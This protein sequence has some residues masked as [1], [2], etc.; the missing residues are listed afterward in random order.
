MALVAKDAL[1]FLDNLIRWSSVNS[2]VFMNCGSNSLYPH[3][4]VVSVRP[5]VRLS[6][7]PFVRPFV[8]PS[9]HASLNIFTS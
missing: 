1:L 5:F 6:V 7:R 8:R 9:V 4:E 2:S 3:G